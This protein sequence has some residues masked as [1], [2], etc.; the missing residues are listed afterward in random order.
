VGAPTLLW[1]HGNAGNIAHRADEFKN[2]VR[3]GFNVLLF[4]YRGY[5][6][7]TGSPS[8]EGIYEDTLG[9]YA[10]LL[11]KGVDPDTIIPYGRSIGSGPALYLANRRSVR[12]LI[13]VQPLTSTYEMGKK[14]FPFLPIKL[15]LREIINNEE[16]I[17]RYKGPLLVMHGNQDD[18]VPFEMGK[19]LFNL[20]PTQSKEFVPLL[21]GD[22]NSLGLTHGGKM[23][24][25][26]QDWL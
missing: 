22:H 14:S 9:A 4:D 13:L 25:A 19:R 17:A 23:I 12:G 8:M 10:F 18:I 24:Q 7:S 15:L 20:A 11:T 21:G 6:E 2:F 16:E 26:I 1:C 5:G 3:A